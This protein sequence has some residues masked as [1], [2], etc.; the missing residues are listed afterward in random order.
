MRVAALTMA[1]NEPV[2]A[3]VWARHYAGQLGAE[4]C[5]I[6]DHGS[7]DGSADN[8]PVRVRRLVP[9]HRGFDR[10]RPSEP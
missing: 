3:G 6:L 10:L 4:H 8:L 9:L 2:W 5:T 7:D 1:Y